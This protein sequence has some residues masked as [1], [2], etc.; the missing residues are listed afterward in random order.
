MR[1]SE[2]VSHVCASYDGSILI[3]SLLIVKTGLCWNWSWLT[4]SDERPVTLSGAATSL[5]QR[6]ENVS[7]LWDCREICYNIICPLQRTCIRRSH[8]VNAASI[9]VFQSFQSL[10]ALHPEGRRPMRHIYIHLYYGRIE[11]MSI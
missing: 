4:L 8:S 7:A 6:S 11:N 3:A 1:G 9:I 5:A 2:T 10:F